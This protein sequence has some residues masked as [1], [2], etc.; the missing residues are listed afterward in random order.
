MTARRRLGLGALLAFAAL[1]LAACTTIPSSGPVNEGN[2]AVSSSEPVVPFADGPREDDSPENIV[3]G[4]IAAS[5]AGFAGDFTVAR[6]FLTPQAAASWDPT[7]KVTVYDSGALNGTFDSTTSTVTYEIPVRATLDDGGRLTEAAGGTRT[8]LTFGMEKNADGQWRISELEDGSILP[9]AFFGRLFT[10]VSLVF[11]SVDETTEV[12]EQRWL[13]MPQNK[14]ATLAASQLIQGPSDALAPAVHT[15]FPAS[16]ALAVNS[17]VVTDGVAAVELTPGSA[18]TSAERSLANEQMTLTLTSIPGIRAVTVTVGGVPIGGDG[19]ADLKQPPVPSSDATAFVNGRLGIW[20]GDDVWQTKDA[21]GALPAG[22]TGVAQ[23]F[24]ARTAAWIV[25]GS[26]LVASTALERGTGGLVKFDPDRVAPGETMTTDT[27]Y[28][29]T[30]LVAPSADRHGWFWTTERGGGDA[31]VAVAEDHTV[32]K[33]LVDWLRGTTVQA[34]SVSGDGARI[35]VLSTTAGKQSLDV[36]SIVRGEDGAP[37]T[38]GQPVTFGADLGPSID[39]TWVDDLKV[40]VLGAGGGEVPND[41]WL[42]DVGGLTTPLK[43]VTGAVDLAAREQERSLLV[44]DSQSQVYAR[45]GT[46]W[47]PVTSGPSELAYAG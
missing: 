45:S 15:G 4:F 3:N 8:T 32:T 24:D 2:G 31:F 46:V 47:S 25:N 35:A 28:T 11:A 19:S 27:L 29:G 18:G 44:V 12:P 20:D 41:L 37:L 21:V 16:S 33:V 5:S 13:P 26:S 10:P 14:A 17:V 43:A 42:V 9:R 36:A 1:A 7:A 40:A 34:L 22:S 23:S 30:N 38:I 39:L 6:E